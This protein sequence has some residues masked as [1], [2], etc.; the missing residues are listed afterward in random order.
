M[1][2]GITR[3]E[4]KGGLAQPRE[5]TVP[6]HLG[7]AEWFGALGWGNTPLTLARLV[8]HVASEGGPKQLLAPGELMLIVLVLLLAPTSGW[9]DRGLAMVPIAAQP[10]LQNECRNPGE[11]SAAASMARRHSDGSGFGSPARSYVCVG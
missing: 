8:G 9:A 1:T 10:V 5:R 6:A 4:M 11:A 3:G 2:S 7:S